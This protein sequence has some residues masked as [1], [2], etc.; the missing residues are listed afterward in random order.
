MRT[1]E[2]VITR[3]GEW[4][5]VV[6][7][8]LL[9]V[10]MTVTVTNIILR[11]VWQAFGGTV[12]IVGWLAAL[13][14]GF[15]LMYSQGKKAHIAIDIVTSRMNQKVRWIIVGMMLLFDSAL[16]G[17]AS[18]RVLLVA[19][20]LLDGGRRSS[21]LQVEYW[22]VVMILAVLIGF[23]AIRLLVDAILAWQKAGSAEVVER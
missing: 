11:Q 9:V 12:E 13:V 1:I 4:L 14:A 20:R 8:I 7:G 17:L 21:T 19:M 3:V 10:M 6:S 5:G 22:Y 15:A 23:F 2:K 16:F 18:W